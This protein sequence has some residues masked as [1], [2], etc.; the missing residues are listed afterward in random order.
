[1]SHIS[2]LYY[3]E[4]SL[5]E[6]ASLTALPASTNPYLIGAIALSMGLHFMIL[7]VPLFAQMFSVVPLTGM[8]WFAV[9][10]ISAP[11]TFIDE[12]LKYITRRWISPPTGS[13]NAEY[14]LYVEEKKQQ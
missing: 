2:L 7:H 9:Y 12:A 13:E 11:I 4:N 1:M 8:E 14:V 6:N 3:I 5:S 10:K